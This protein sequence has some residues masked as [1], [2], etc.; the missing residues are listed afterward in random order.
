MPI[1]RKK[2]MGTTKNIVVDVYGCNEE[3]YGT[4]R[5]KNC[6]KERIDGKDGLPDSIYHFPLR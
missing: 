4:R 5:S 6:N 1:G 3:G 2:E